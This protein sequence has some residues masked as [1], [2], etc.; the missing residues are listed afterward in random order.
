MSS[1]LDL[2]QIDTIIFDFDGTLHQGEELSL[3]IFEHCLK[4]L[5]EKYRISKEYPTTEEILSQFGKQTEDIY[6][7]LLKTNDPEIINFFSKCVEQSEVLAF[8]AGKGNLYPKVLETLNALKKRKFKLALCT[9]ARV[10]YFEAVV[11]RFKLAE[12]FD[13]MAAAGQYP[14]KNKLWMVKNIV[15]EL[16]AKSFAVVGDRHHDIEAAKANKGIA[17]GCTYG[18]GKDEV[19]KADIKITDFEELLSIFK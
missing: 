10:D 8:N 13:L 2:S 7:S 5:Y 4:S 9:N 15:K 16:G 19:E 12:Y 1:N 11:K 6:P 14:G 18:F 3:P 17:I